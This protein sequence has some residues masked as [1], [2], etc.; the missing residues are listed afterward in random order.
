MNDDYKIRYSSQ[1]L[2][3]LKDIFSY[4]A[5]ELSEPATAQN[6]INKIRSEVKSLGFMPMRNKSVD[7]E[8]WKSMG[9]HETSVHNFI[10]F[11]TVD[12]AQLTVRIIRVVYGGRDMEAALKG[13]A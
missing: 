12:S 4:I 10:I 5:Y 6:L 8:P 11:Y 2:E 3:D 1:A 7:W 9:M 13:R